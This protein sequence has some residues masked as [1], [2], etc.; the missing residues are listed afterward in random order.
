MPQEG[1]YL[2]PIHLS[3]KLKGLKNLTYANIYKLPKNFNAR[4]KLMPYAIKWSA[5]NDYT[6]AQK[7]D[8]LLYS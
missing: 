3:E 7:K 8:C 5:I 1:E 4:Y 2:T 6:E